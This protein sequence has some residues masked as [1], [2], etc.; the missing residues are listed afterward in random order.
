MFFFFFTSLLRNYMKIFALSHGSPV[1]SHNSPWHAPLPALALA[2]I[3]MLFPRGGAIA[4]VGLPNNPPF[5]QP[6]AFV[7]GAADYDGDGRTGAAENADGDNIFSSISAIPGFD[8]PTGIIGPRITYNHVIIVTSGVFP[9]NIRTTG[10]APLD[11]TIE[12]APGVIAVFDPNNIDPQ[13]DAPTVRVS[14]AVT[15]RNLTFRNTSDII[16]VAAGGTLLVEGCH[17]EDCGG[18]FAIVVERGGRAVVRDC[19]I[20]RCGD[21]ATGQ[22]GGIRVARGADVIV[23]DCTITGNFGAGV[24]RKDMSLRL[25]RTIIAHNNPN[26]AD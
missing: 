11:Y 20:T 16:R 25:L 26:I 8:Q 15:L 4:D 13:P 5:G 21:K 19:T 10:G 3:A 24:V 18:G 17:F 23:S 12:A 7:E 1:V 2:A 9:V 22:G 6:T 14:T